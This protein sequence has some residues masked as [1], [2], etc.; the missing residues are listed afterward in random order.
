MPGATTCRTCGAE[1]TPTAVECATCGTP[2]DTLSAEATVKRDSLVGARL[3]DFEVRERIGAGGMGIVYEGVH[4]VI[5][6]RVAI[7]VLRPEIG[8]DDEQVQ[9]LLSE[10][11]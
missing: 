11:R 9:R 4:S 7:K 2:V 3:G 1:L 8:D 10:A 5:G 6:K